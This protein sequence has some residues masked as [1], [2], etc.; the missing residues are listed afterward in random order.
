MALFDIMLSSG[1]FLAL[2]AAQ[3]ISG[4]PRVVSCVVDVPVLMC[5][6]YLTPQDALFY[7]VCM[8]DCYG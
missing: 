5:V 2:P 4:C 8:D 3:G 7:S 1:V 6:Y